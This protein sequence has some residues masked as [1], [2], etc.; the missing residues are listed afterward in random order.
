M[1]QVKTL[2]I[3]ATR[4]LSLLLCA[5]TAATITVFLSKVGFVQKAYSSLGAILHANPVLHYSSA[6]LAGIGIK[7]L[8]DKFYISHPKR[9]VGFNWRYPP[10]TIAVLASLLITAFYMLSTAAK[11]NEAALY[12][13]S[14]MSLKYLALTFIGMQ[15]TVIYQIKLY[16]KKPIFTAV[17]VA[18]S[19]MYVGFAVGLADIAAAFYVFISLAVNYLILAIY[20]VGDE[21]RQSKQQDSVSKNELL[22]TKGSSELKTLED[23]R[24][25]FKDDSTIKSTDQLEP[26][27]KVYA[28]RI[29]ERLQNGGDKYEKDLAQH[30]ALCGPYGCG[31]SSIVESVVNDLAKKSEKESVWIHSDIS[32]WGTASGSVAHVILSNIIDDISQYIDMCAFRALPKHYT[33]ALKSGGSVFQFAS[34][35]L[36]G[37]VDIEG[38]FQNLNDVLDATN[39]KLLITLQDVDRGTGD[40]N[41][42]RLN[43]IAALLD[44]LKNRRLSHINFIIAMGNESEVAAEVISKAT[45]YRDDIHK[46]SI[47]GVLLK[48][49]EKSVL[50]AIE[51]QRV[52]II[53]NSEIL[54]KEEL[55]SIL[56]GNKKWYGVN[57]K[58]I[59]IENQISSIRQ[60]K[61]ILCRVNQVWQKEKLMGEINLFNL[62]MVITLKETNI[63]SFEKY[64]KLEKDNIKSLVTRGDYDLKPFI[65]E[66]AK[67]KTEESLI[68]FYI[69]MLDITA[70]S[71]LNPAIN[72]VLD[73]PSAKWQQH[74]ST[75]NQ[76]VGFNNGYSD[77]LS[78]ILSEEVPKYQVSDQISIANVL[79]LYKLKPSDTKGILLFINQFLSFSDKE[80]VNFE[81][82][83]GL[84]DNKLDITDCIGKHFIKRG[85]FVDYAVNNGVEEIFKKLLAES[86]TINKLHL[87]FDSFL[88]NNKIYSDNIGNNIVTEFLYEF[89]TFLGVTT[90]SKETFSPQ[91]L[92]DAIRSLNTTENPLGYTFFYTLLI[93]YKNNFGV[94]TGKVSLLDKIN[95]VQ[96]GDHT[97]GK[98]LVGGSLQSLPQLD[99][100]QFM[101]FKHA[102]QLNKE[103]EQL[104]GK[105]LIEG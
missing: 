101:T 90:S 56:Y 24:E 57:S 97:L 1:S 32:T 25:W 23:F 76:S 16:T 26:D 6:F 43:D 60:L 18:L 85:F 73:N 3:T 86:L 66:C 78:R 17:L 19:T 89:L 54:N 15:I 11:L 48:F 65:H 28:N 69:E 8:L 95:K 42:K 70:D 58:L 63:K 72:H 100:K 36:A 71:V 20:L 99:K 80:V 74:G 41:E 44:R 35:L 105:E 38:S 22:E 91:S 21:Y 12:A 102:E 9:S 49:T 77:Y 83:F 62:M 33:E 2:P 104:T 88:S 94:I 68:T 87:I 27:L 39:H 37:P 67:N 40:E 82:F 64:K 59:E 50:D 93:S 10:V 79:E 92:I 13:Q 51:E 14:F 75:K 103:I 29:T 5:I 81:R 96:V 55:T 7:L 98:L 31:K 34:T 46:P 45:D 47:M 4:W 84:I 30:I 52:F 61:K 53:E